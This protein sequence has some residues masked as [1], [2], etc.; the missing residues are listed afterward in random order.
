MRDAV[1]DVQSRGVW[2]Q[3]Q[4]EAL[5]R[6]FTKLADFLDERLLLRG[7]RVQRNVTLSGGDTGFDIPCK[8]APKS[9]QMLTA[10]QGSLVYTQVPMQWTWNGTDSVRLADYTGLLSAA[11]SGGDLTV[12]VLLERA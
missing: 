9:V 12:D 8:F 6:I 7:V 5:V 10:R 3:P 1:A 4:K 2:S 11:L